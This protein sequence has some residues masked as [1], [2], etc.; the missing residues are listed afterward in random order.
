VCFAASVERA[1]ARAC[2]RGASAAAADTS[3]AAAARVSVGACVAHCGRVVLPLR[4]GVSG[5][6]RRMDSVGAAFTLGGVAACGR[7]RSSGSL[8]RSKA[9]RRSV[10]H[11]ERD[12]TVAIRAP[13]RPHEEVSRGETGGVEFSSRRQLV[14]RA[15]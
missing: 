12:I 7:V 1:P 5:R 14:R 13:E 2:R 15:R 3:P 8:V 11:D 4:D 10:A 9:R 6:A